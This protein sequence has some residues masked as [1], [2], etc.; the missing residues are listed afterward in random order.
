FVTMVEEVL[1]AWE[2]SDGSFGIFDD[3]KLHLLREIDF[4]VIDPYIRKETIILD[5][6]S[7][8]L[9]YHCHPGSKWLDEN[10]ASRESSEYT[11]ANQPCKTPEFLPLSLPTCSL[12]AQIEFHNLHRWT[13]WRHLLVITPT[14][15][16]DIYN[17][18][19]IDR[20]TTERVLESFVIAFKNIK[21]N[22]PVFVPTGQLSNSLYEGHL[23]LFPQDLSNEQFMKFRFHMLQVRDV[24]PAH[25]HLSGL[26][27]LFSEKLK[28]HQR[29][30]GKFCIILIYIR[31]QS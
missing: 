19:S 29:L 16:S 8:T 27:S 12:G 11:S 10:T 7:Y 28:L 30:H 23:C 4:K 14:T 5:D 24:Q 22:L 3:S 6:N 25:T 15:R 18:S 17:T 31:S 13:G 1:R 20:S 26:T 2:V 21:C 9:S